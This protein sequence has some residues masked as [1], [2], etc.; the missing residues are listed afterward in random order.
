MFDLPRG[1]FPTT[2]DVLRDALEASVRGRMKLPT[3]HAAVSLDMN[4]WPD[5]GAL[6]V[7]VT[8]GHID[9]SGDPRQLQE[10]MRPPT[11]VRDR[12]GGPS[13]AD[14]AVVGEPFYAGDMACRLE[15]VGKNVRFDFGRDADGTP[16]MAPAA[17]EG[18]LFGSVPKD[19][20]L[21]FIKAKARQGAAEKNV[22]LDRVDADVTAP[23]PR[24]LAIAGTLHGHKKLGF[25]NPSF[26]IDFAARVSVDDELV[27]RITQLDLRGHGVVMETLIGLIRPKLE[28]IKREPV[29]IRE[30]LGAVVPA[31]LGMSDLKIEVG[32][33]IRLSAAFGGG[34]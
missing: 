16:V 2:P 18:T 3:G 28:E 23:D 9:V 10:D 29:A 32:D 13:F 19:Q 6:R 33:T 31:G 4:G 34:A 14:F 21:A 30:V 5:G 1:D 8:G 17:G 25:L 20:F 22:T 7:D 12:R 24:S 11:I 15:A 27:G 26:T